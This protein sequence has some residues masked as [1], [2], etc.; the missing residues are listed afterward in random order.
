M[1]CQSAYIINVIT[2]KNIY[3]MSSLHCHHMSLLHCHH[4]M[5]SQ[6]S[7]SSHKMPMITYHPFSSTAMPIITF[8][9][10]H[11]KQWQSS[12]GIA[13]LPSFVIPIITCHH[14]HHIQCQSSHIIPFINCNAY[15]HISSLS[16]H[17]MPIITCHQCHH[18]QCQSSS[19]HVSTVI[20][21]DTNHKWH[22]CHCYCVEC[23]WHHCHTF[24]C[25][26]YHVITVIKCNA[27]DQSLSLKPHT[28]A[29]QTYGD[30]T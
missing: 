30:H 16:S 12:H 19:S 9:H 3:R 26:S 29:R 1:Q 25:Q 28:W 8:H 22:H 18:M 7:L 24:Q 11:H 20:T 14:C 6:S 2:W 15:H 27:N 10:C 17:A 5:W 13:A 23:K 4:Y 21:Y